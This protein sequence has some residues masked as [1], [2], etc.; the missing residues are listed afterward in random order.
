MARQPACNDDVNARFRFAATGSRPSTPLCLAGR[1]YHLVLRSFSTRVVCNEVATAA[2]IAT[3]LNYLCDA[4]RVA[5]L[6]QHDRAN[7]LEH[8]FER[9]QAQK[10]EARTTTE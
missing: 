8:T 3:K 10:A 7:G 5:L 1:R 6:P 2:Y 9:L 4:S